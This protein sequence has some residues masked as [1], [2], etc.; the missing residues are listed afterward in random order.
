MND[1]C[2][3]AMPCGI[4]F[5]NDRRMLISAACSHL[6][7]PCLKVAFCKELQISFKIAIQLV[8]VHIA[9]AGV[10]GCKSYI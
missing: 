6:P 8:K 2:N 7:E 10:S 4:C 1:D 9:D 3:V 5:T